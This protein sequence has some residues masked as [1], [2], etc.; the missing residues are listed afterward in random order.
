MS[1]MSEKLN[2]FLLDSSKDMNFGS[3]KTVMSWKKTSVYISCPQLAY[4]TAYR[5]G[6][7]GHYMRALYS[8]N[9]PLTCTLYAHTMYYWRK[10]CGY[11]DNCCYADDS[12]KGTSRVTISWAWIVFLHPIYNIKFIYTFL[13]FIQFEAIKELWCVGWW[14]AYLKIASGLINSA[15]LLCSI[16]WTVSAKKLCAVHRGKSWTH[17]ELVLV[18][19]LWE[20]KH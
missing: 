6:R 4:F 15:S 13:P 1:K 9:L 7:R 16:N 2:I 14:H 17:C 3:R 18:I 11:L 12:K 19:H 10:E 8:H 20:K 5:S